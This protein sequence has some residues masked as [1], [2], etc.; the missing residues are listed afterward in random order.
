MLKIFSKFHYPKYF[1]EIIY[2]RLGWYQVF[3][4]VYFFKKIKTIKIGH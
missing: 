4:G 1:P 2:Y 3:L